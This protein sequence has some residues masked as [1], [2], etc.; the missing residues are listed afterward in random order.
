MQGG[1]FPSRRSGSNAFIYIHFN[2]FAVASSSYLSVC[3]CMDSKTVALVDP[4]FVN[5]LASSIWT[6][7]SI[8][9]PSQ[10][11]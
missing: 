4:L 5:L 7:A 8:Y 1:T 11:W 3:Y 9:S 6:L 10:S 2:M